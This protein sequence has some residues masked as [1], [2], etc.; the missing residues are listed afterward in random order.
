LRR[1]GQ[2]LVMGDTEQLPP[3]I[4]FGHLVDDD[5]QASEGE[6]ATASVTEVES[7]LHQ[8]KRSYP[9]KYL[10]WHYR[11]QH[12]SL[13]AVSNNLFYEN[14]LRAFPSAF[15]EHEDFGLHFRHLPETVYDRGKSA[16]NREEAKAVARA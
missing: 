9:S 10:T 1:G 16:T 5:G 2:L 8:C 15:H 11:S 4:V 14:R 7:I 3:T 12:D 13:I 6:E